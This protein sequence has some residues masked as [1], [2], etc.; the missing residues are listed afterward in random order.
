MTT[1]RSASDYKGPSSYRIMAGAPHDWRDH[2]TAALSVEVARKA[3]AFHQS[4]VEGTDGK[5]EARALLAALEA[6]STGRGGL[7][8]VL[9]E[10]FSQSIEHLYRAPVSLAMAERMQAR[11]LRR[12]AELERRGYV[13]LVAQTKAA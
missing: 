13:S 3:E 6:L 12:L 1:T 8:T 11:A 10:V 4:R 9:S 5:A 7:P 2:A